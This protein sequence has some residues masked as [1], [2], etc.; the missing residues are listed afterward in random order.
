[1]FST[2]LCTTPAVLFSH[3][4]RQIL[5][6][7]ADLSTYPPSYPQSVF[8]TPIKWNRAHST[9]RQLPAIKFFHNN[10]C[11]INR[12]AI[13]TCDIPPKRLKQTENHFSADFLFADEKYPNEPFLLNFTIKQ[14]TTARPCVIFRYSVEAARPRRV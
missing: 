6:P 13:Y 8:F 2:P 5:L 11:C 14:R 1:M 12:K 9:K 10:V 4:F 7:L 3:I